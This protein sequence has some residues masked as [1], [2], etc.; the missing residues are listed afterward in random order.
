MSK[1]KHEHHAEPEA[2]FEIPA[3]VPVDVPAPVPADVTVEPT[4]VPVVVEPEPVAVAESVPEPCSPPHTTFK[5]LVR[6]CPS[7]VPHLFIQAADK[8]DALKK[9]L[10]LYPGCT[11]SIV[12]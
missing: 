9:V 5:V 7:K 12:E 11:P 1:K 3:E 4:P 10:A 6:H 2:V 8:A